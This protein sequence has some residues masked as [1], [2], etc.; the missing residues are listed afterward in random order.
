MAIT[1]LGAAR[2]GVAVARLLTSR[3]AS[4]FV[5]DTASDDSLRTWLVE[6]AKDDIPFETGK[7]SE[8]VFASDLLVVSPGVPSDAD[9]VQDAI[10][11]GIDVVSELECASWFHTGP[12]AAITGSNGK[13]TT[14]SLIGRML[15]DARVKHTVAG[16]IVGCVECGG[17]RKT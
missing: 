16:N 12:I 3:G 1:V 8:R 2:S 14:T 6:L 13:T 4:V 9:V 11:R 17:R 7:H 5:S 15:G 10:K